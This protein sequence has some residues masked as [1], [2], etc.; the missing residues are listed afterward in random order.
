[1]GG[2]MKN[3]VIKTI[4]VDTGIFSVPREVYYST[5]LLDRIKN[6]KKETKKQKRILDRCE[7]DFCLTTFMKNVEKVKLK[8]ICND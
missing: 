5:Y 3:N 2:K 7:K 6:L 4:N 8:N 1:M